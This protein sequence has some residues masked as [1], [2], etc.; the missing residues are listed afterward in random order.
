[1]DKAYYEEYYHLERKHWW[2]RARMNI[3]RSMVASRIKPSGDL[4]ILNAGAATGATSEMLQEFGEVT[5]LEFDTE[6]YEVLKGLVSGEVVN[7]SLTALPF[8]DNSFDLVCAFDVIEHIEDDNLA[9]SEIWRVLKGNGQV[10]ITVPAFMSLWSHHDVVNHH[11]RRYT[12]SNLSELVRH[13]RFNIEFVSYFNSA[14]FLPI[15][16]FRTLSN[17]LSLGK[18]RK[19]SG[20]D[21]ESAGSNKLLDPALYAIFNSEKGLLSRG[22]HFPFGVSAML[23]ARKNTE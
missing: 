14:L 23:I 18:S 11:F 3:L 7:E 5:S 12:K 2:F 22:M 15:L 19:G 6:C 1:M 8:E 21:F 10:F 20:S 4:R 17:A 9:L 16:A 13:N